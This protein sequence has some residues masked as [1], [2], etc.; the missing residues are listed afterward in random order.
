MDIALSSLPR[1]AR[2]VALDAAKICLDLFKVMVPILI[3]VKILKELGRPT[4]LI[5]GAS[6]R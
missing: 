3:G 6:G 2:T 5:S 1:A 4:R